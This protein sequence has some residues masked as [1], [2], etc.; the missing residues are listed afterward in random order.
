MVCQCFVSG[1]TLYEL[2]A[3]LYFIA[4]RE[5]RQGTIKSAELKSKLEEVLRLLQ[6]AQ[7]ILSFDYP[8]TPEGVIAQTIGTS[9]EGVQLVIKH[10]CE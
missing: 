1:L 2:H 8:N 9:I 6:E 10:C 7:A 4:Q 5:S 3:A